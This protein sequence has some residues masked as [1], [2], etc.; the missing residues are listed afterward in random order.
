M[1]VNGLHR[2]EV[3][4]VFLGVAAI[5]QTVVIPCGRHFRRGTHGV[6]TTTDCQQGVI[7]AL[8]IGTY[9]YQSDRT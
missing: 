4:L 7:G 1:R 8:Y 9:E 3:R 2:T 5:R 6:D